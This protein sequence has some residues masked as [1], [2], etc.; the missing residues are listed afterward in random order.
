MHSSSDIRRA[1]LGAG[2]LAA[3]VAG[4]FEVWPDYLNVELPP[5]I[6]PLN[7][8]V[9]GAAEDAAVRVT[10]TAPDG[11]AL[12]TDGRAC[13]VRFPEGAWRA[14]LG[15]HAGQPLAGVLRVGEAT[16][17]FTNAVSK[18]PIDSHLTYRLIP[19]SYTGFAEVGIYQRD[20]TAF[21]ERALYRN[22]QDDRMQ[23]VNCHTYNA[24]D[25][26]QYLFHT[27]AR[28][29]GTM[30]VSARYG[31]A[32]VVPKVPGGYG[33][34]V[35]PAWHPSG[36]FIAFSCND[37]SQLFYTANPDKIEVFDSRSDL[38]LY[39]LSDGRV[40]MIEQSPLVF[41][42]YPAW[43]P[44]GK[45][46]VS[47]AARV[48]FKE[49]AKEKADRE[50]MVGGR[51]TE[52]LYDLVIRTFDSTALAFSQPRILVNAQVSKRSF[53]FPRVSPD[54]R[55][56]VFTASS[57]GVFSIWRREADLWIYDRGTGTVRRLDELNSNQAE[58]Y[59][60]FSRDGRWMV[61]SSRRDD[62][63]Y[64]RPYFA[65]FDPATGR[66]AKPFLLPVREPSEHGRRMLSYNIP[67][68]S[69]GPV[70]ESPREL[71]RLVQGEPAAAPRR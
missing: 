57:H 56:I 70:A 58:S 22:V 24:G 47:V 43:S 15:R 31:K 63:A 40:T 20:L 10:L 69:A 65:A 54:G 46:L 5:N 21:R 71:R 60:C 26:G 34:G 33:G 52:I 9:R 62:G 37:T 55:W 38:F 30:I 2:L 11:D 61:F 19:P 59:H 6:A 13:A 51:Y 25:P 1:L 8:D 67:E 7:F 48:P 53:T 35:Y 32:R 44:D 68:L 36:D 12:A 45:S 49:L 64:T 42:C 3:T 66:F 41:E 39:R 27:R 23:C 4:A 16:L 29:A 50:R 17:A 14:F 18:F 28:H